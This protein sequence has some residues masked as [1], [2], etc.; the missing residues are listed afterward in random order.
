MM[1]LRGCLIKK[2][3]LTNCLKLKLLENRSQSDPSEI[4]KHVIMR[5]LY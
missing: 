1:H 4:E 3:L 5:V 2:K